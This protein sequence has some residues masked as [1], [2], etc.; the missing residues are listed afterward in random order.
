M[1]RVRERFRQA[2]RNGWFFPG[3]VP[4]KYPLSINSDPQSALTRKEQSY[5]EAAVLFLIGCKAESR[6]LQVLVTKRSTKV[7]S[8]AGISNAPRSICITNALV[9]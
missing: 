2:E 9:M 5:G 1:E 8:H 4:V 6:Q 3:A 7:G